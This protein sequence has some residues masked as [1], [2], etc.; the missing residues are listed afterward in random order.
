MTMKKI[1]LLAGILVTGAVSA[2]TITPGNEND[3]NEVVLKN[4]NDNKEIISNNE[5]AEALESKSTLKRECATVVV[6]CTSA[7]TC[8]DWTPQ[9][10]ID[11]GTQIQ[12]NYC[13]IDSPFTP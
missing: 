12:N 1:I 4:G 13:M 9:Q 7:Y 3:K 10:W 8:Q 5:K 2:N 11:W 6:T